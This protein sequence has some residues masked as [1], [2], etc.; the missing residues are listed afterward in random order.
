MAI[1]EKSKSLKADKGWHNAIMG[2]TTDS[3][4]KNVLDNFMALDEDDEYLLVET[5]SMKSHVKRLSC[6]EEICL[7]VEAAEI[8]SADK[9]EQAASSTHNRK[10]SDTT[11]EDSDLVDT[12]AEEEATNVN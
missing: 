11:A 7:G 10:L 9:V 2:C 5:T 1:P 6:F 4:E 12:K 8:K 3:E